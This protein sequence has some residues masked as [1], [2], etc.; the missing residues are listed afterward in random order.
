MPI[1]SFLSSS[2]A[3]VV[4]GCAIL[5]GA[6]CTMQ[7]EA[8]TKAACRLTDAI[9]TTVY[10]STAPSCNNLGA[11]ALEVIYAVNSNG[12]AGTATV[13]GT[14]CMATTSGAPDCDVS[15]SCPS[16]AVR[17]YGTYTE[18]NASFTRVEFYDTSSSCTLV[19][20]L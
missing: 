13:N 4:S 8:P 5:S 7:T 20:K 18:P 10:P 1:Q 14:A 2:L 12:A 15:I 9:Q 17:V 19:S 3:L 6:G 11:M 16:S